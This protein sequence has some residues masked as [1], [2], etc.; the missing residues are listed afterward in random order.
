MRLRWTALFL[1][2]YLSFALP[3]C[4]SKPTGANG[5]GDTSS[6]NPP[7]PRVRRKPRLRRRGRCSFPPAPN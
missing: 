5:S 4:S 6:T 1:S 2:F 7:T 3:G